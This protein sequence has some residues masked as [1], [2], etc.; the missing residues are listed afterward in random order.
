MKKRQKI[1]L[2][3]AT[4]AVT[5]TALGA[6]LIPAEIQ[7]ED[8]NVESNVYER[9]KNRMQEFWGEDFDA[10][11][12][13]ERFEL[14]E[15]EREARRAEREAEFNDSELSQY[16]D[17]TH[18]ELHDLREDGTSLSEY[19]EEQGL[20][21]LVVLD[22]MTSQAEEHLAEKLESGEITQE[23]YSDRI[24]NLEERIQNRLDGERGEGFGE[25]RKG[26]GI[27]F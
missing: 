10:D 26:R 3:A 15:A 13:E 9:L 14:M 27:R 1:A 11:T 21:E 17:L 16:L 5:F 12:F 7:A 2:G 18:D 8:V 22:L 23:E 19:I 25:S 4:A 20:D 24:E 6:M